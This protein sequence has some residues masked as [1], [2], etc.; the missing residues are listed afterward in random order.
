MD[1]KAH[2][3][4]SVIGYSYVLYQDSLLNLTVA[5][6]WPYLN[7]PICVTINIDCCIQI[8][9]LTPKTDILG[10]LS[11]SCLIANKKYY[12]LTFKATIVGAMMDFAN[13][14]NHDHRLVLIDNSPCPPKTYSLTL[15]LL[16]YLL[17]KE[18][19]SQLKSKAAIVLAILDLSHFVDDEHIL[20][21]INGFLA[22]EN[23]YLN[24]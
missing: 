18:S 7:R 20:L 1:V 19:Y 15:E 3:C 21:F 22:P 4:L 14:C 13:V 12:L 6:V 17:C 2:L 8:D 11:L 16:F 23:I 9:Y 24:I 5:I 10:P